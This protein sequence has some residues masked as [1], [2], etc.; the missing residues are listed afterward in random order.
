[1]QYLS[2]LK[3][4]LSN[5]VP[6]IPFFYCIY[7]LICIFSYYLLFPIVILL[8]LWL[9]DD[10]HNSRNTAHFLFI[11]FKKERGEY[12]LLFSWLSYFFLLSV[13][14]IKGLLFTFAF[15]RRKNWRYRWPESN[16]I[17]QIK[18]S[19]GCRIPRGIILDGPTGI[20]K[21]RYKLF[22][23]VRISIYL[24]IRSRVM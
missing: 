10:S 8:D 13:K 20:G 2:I 23:H 14:I 9:R 21:V 17:L 24:L 11:I 15:M 7:Y 12:R 18:V 22:K 5:L 1:M 6:K 19:R 4:F 3:Q 16:S